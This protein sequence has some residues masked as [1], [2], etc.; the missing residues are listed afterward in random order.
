MSNPQLIQ[1]RTGQFLI[2]SC[3]T[4]DDGIVKITNP[5]E[6]VIEPEHTPQ[7][8]MPRAGMFPYAM[9]SKVRSF[10]FSKDQLQLN[11]CDADDNCSK[12]WTQATSSIAI[13]T[14]N[15]SRVLLKG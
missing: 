14:S 2:G 11:P 5:F 9:M 7:G 3:E 4:G 12:N 10:S 8:I 13:P 1:L 6:I 15:D